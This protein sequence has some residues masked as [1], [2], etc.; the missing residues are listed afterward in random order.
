V[1][2]TLQIHFFGKKGTQDLNFDGFFNFMKN[3]QTEVLELEFH[4]FSKGHEKISEVDFAKILLRYTYLDTE[5]YDNYLDRLL[6]R[7]DM[8]EK[9]VSF[10]E[11]KQ[12]CQFLNN[13]EDFSIAM[14]MYTLADRSISKGKKIKFS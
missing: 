7:D 9:G 6:D 3:L 10:E 12:F 5:E 2:T 14:R 1:D 13:L 4:E 11:F 8:K